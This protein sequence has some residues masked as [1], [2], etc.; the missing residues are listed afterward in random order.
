M[1][2]IARFGGA[3]QYPAPIPHREREIKMKSP[4]NAL[5]IL[6]FIVIAGFFVTSA[7]AQ[8]GSILPQKANPSLKPQSWQGQG[9]FQ[10]ASLFDSDD[11]DPI[12][13][14]WVVDFTAQGNND[15]H[16]P[17]GAPIDHAIVQ[18]HSDKTEIMNS[19]RPPASQSF[20][21]GVWKRVGQAKYK[22]NH[23]AVSWDPGNLT[24]PVGPANIIENVNLD[25]SGNSFSGTFDLTQYD[26]SGNVIVHIVGTISGKRLTANSPV[27][28]VL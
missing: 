22:L 6:G 16:F 7:V 19:S 18:W 5:R 8:C 26:G 15:P 17:D 10:P 2:S 9:H 1:L 25:S 24:A 12:V 20:C 14:M 21:L 3:R 23:F 28:A 11:V 4:K 13:G 27:S